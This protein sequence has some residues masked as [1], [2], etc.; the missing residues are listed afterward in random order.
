MQHNRNA[1]SVDRRKMDLLEPSLAD[2]K[3]SGSPS[4]DSDVV[5]QLF[6]PAREKLNT[7]RD[8]RVF[9]PNSFGQ[10]LRSCLVNKNRYGLAD[11][12]IGMAFYG[13][14]G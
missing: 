8:Y 3:D 13:R 1:D 12:V 9:G 2:L 5:L 4:Q 7:Y 10:I 11:K 6:Y 14:A